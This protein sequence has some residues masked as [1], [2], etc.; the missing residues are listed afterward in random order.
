MKKIITV[1]VG[2]EPKI[3]NYR[4]GSDTYLDYGYSK[5]RVNVEGSVHDVI[6]NLTRIKNEY[7]DKYQD[8]Q[9]DSINDCG[10]RFDCSC[11]PTY[12]VTGKRMENDI[13]Y[14]YRVN[15]ANENAVRI[16]TAERAAYEA[17]KKKFETD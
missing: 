16:Q 3:S 5:E 10:C 15:K 12:Y 7:G 14:N 8:L 9:I 6:A 11:P 1:P 4:G 2:A 13:E 17:L